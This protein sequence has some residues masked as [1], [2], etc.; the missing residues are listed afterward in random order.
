MLKPESFPVYPNMFTTVFP[1]VFNVPQTNRVS[2]IARKVAVVLLF[3]LK[4]EAVISVIVG[5]ML[6]TFTQEHL[7]FPDWGSL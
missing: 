1:V 3:T 7:L 4:C 6:F 2:P 5:S